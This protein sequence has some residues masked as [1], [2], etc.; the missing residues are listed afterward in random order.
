MPILAVPFSLSLPKKASVDGGGVQST[1]Y[2]VRGMAR[3]DGDR[4]TIEWSGSVDITEVRGGGVRTMR[5]SVPAQRL[6]LPA[7]RIARF[8]ARGRWWKP[9][10]ELR[11]DSIAPLELMPTAAAGRVIL[12][13]ARS[14]WGAARD[15]ASH[16]QLAMADAALH[17]AERT[18]NLAPE[19]VDRQPDTR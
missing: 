10:I 7:S 13:I 6:V 19:S 1:V 5:Q 15:L 8:E 12:R 9:Y 3:L 17:E 4:L 16:V 11:T 14:D 2:Q 18:R